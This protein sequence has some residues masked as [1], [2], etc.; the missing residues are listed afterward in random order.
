MRGVKKGFV[1]G[2]MSSQHKAKIAAAL[3]GRLRPAEAGRP[4]NTPEILWSK[5]D[6]RG[7]EECWHW[8]GNTNEQGYGRT[9]IQ[10]KS[11]YA[12]RVIYNLVYPGVITLEA[13]TDR[14]AVGFLRHSCDNPPCCN[15]DHLIVGTHQENMDDKVTRGRMPDYRG[16]RGPR[17]KLT[18]ED[19]FWIRMQKKYGATKKALA[20]LYEVSESTISGACYGRHYQDVL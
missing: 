19:V 9:E 8:I 1:R 3:K 16:S 18:D 5:V 20:M 12:H 14:N 11:Y 6:K 2:P 4:A 7:P 10:D 13:P 15:P 17:A